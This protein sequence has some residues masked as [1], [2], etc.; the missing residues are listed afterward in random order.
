MADREKLI[1]ML[2]TIYK[3]YSV[4]PS[5]DLIANYLISHGVTVREKGE[6]IDKRGGTYGRWSAYCSACG[7]KCGCGGTIESQHKDY[8]PNCGAD[9]RGII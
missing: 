7:K 9:M 4:S 2:K 6:W 8:C 5:D 1:E 3:E